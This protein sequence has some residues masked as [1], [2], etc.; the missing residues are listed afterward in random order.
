MGRGGRG[1]VKGGSAPAGG[2]FFVVCVIRVDDVFPKMTRLPH[3][4]FGHLV[5]PHSRAGGFLVP[6][7]GTGPRNRTYV[8]PDRGV[9]PSPLQ[10]GVPET[11]GGSTSAVGTVPQAPGTTV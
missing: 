2:N 11:R 5:T 8:I 1:G 7:V 4:E 6:T 3:S 9:C 10:A